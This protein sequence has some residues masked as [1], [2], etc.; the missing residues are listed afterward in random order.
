M[1]TYI[2]DDT[3]CA[4]SSPSGSGAI[5][6]IRISGKQAENIVTQCFKH[7][8]KKNLS[9]R[10]CVYGQFYDGEYLVDDIVVTLYKAPN[11][12]TGEDLLELS[13]HGS[14]FIQQYI[15]NLLVAKGAR[16]ALPGEFTYRAFKNGKLDLTRSEAVADLIAAENAQAH[17][18]AM[19]QLKGTY[20]GKIASLRKRLLE[21]TSLFELELDFAEEDVEFAK[22]EDLLAL[23]DE[24]ESN[25][26]ELID[27]FKMGNALKN[28]IAVA[29]IG[30]PNVGKSTLLNRLLNEDKA[31]V[32][33]IPGTT[34]D[35]VEDVI[36]IGGFPFRFIDTAGL[37]DTEDEIETLGMEKTLQR[38][39]QAEIVLHVFDAGTMEKDDLMKEIDE[40]RQHATAEKKWIMIGNKVD[41]LETL[42]S[43]FT[44]LQSMDCIYISAKRNENIKL[45][46]D[47]LL[48][49]VKS[50][51]VTGSTVV[52]NVRH[53]QAMQQTL[54]HITSAED[55]IL[56]GVPMDLTAIDLRQAGYYL[57]T[58]TG[59]ITNTEILDNIFG[60]FC[61]G[62]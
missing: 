1:N 19:S 24:I 7:S 59:E 46:T 20:A 28:G 57:G 47:D 14:N 22:K 32:S 31:I 38:I 53:V 26:E 15:L 12:Y 35:V 33:D 42:P 5:A 62:K 40:F 45:V 23:M 25:L 41:Q 11:S 27:S 52:T 43:Y 58:I 8:P 51:H 13:C 50:K 60:N 61:I 17:D 21:L 6:L 39:N 34:R 54:E 30:R 2:N 3:I 48:A 18:V 49:Y 55:G 36:T 29:I 16:L 44:E 56:S 4:I 9:D 10:K 37:R